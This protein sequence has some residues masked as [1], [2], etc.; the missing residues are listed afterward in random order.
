MG[1][2]Y[3]E[4]MFAGLLA[5]CEVAAL[6]EPEHHVEKTVTRLAIRD[7]KM[8]AADGA[9]ADAAERKNSGLD[10][11]F[12]DEFDNLAHVDGIVE[13]GGIFDREMRHDG[14]LL[15]RNSS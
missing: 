14:S 2:Q 6:A 9:D 10:C 4:N 15:R 7:R 12:A 3:L 13:I 8:L 5:G 1:R 11:G